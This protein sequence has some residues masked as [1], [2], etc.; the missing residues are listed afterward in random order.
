MK[1]MKCTKDVVVQGRT[2]FVKEKVYDFEAVKTNGVS[3]YEVNGEGGVG[4]ISKDDKI[5]KKNFVKVKKKLF[6][7]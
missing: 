3:A 5:L 4:V 6:R 7:K 1:Q 2:V